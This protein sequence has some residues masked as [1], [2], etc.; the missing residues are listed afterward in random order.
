MKLQL[1]FEDHA[2]EVRYDKASPL[3]QSTKS[4][5]PRVLTRSQEG[6][7][8]GKT[9]LE[10][11]ADLEAKYKIVETFWEMEEDDFVEMLEDAFADTIEEVMT[12]E[13][14]SKKGVSIKETDKIEAKFRQNLANRRYDGVIS[15]VPTTA[16][17]RGVS[18][19]RQHPYAKRAPRPSF[20]DT[21]MYQRSFR[22]W[23]EDIDDDE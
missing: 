22:V 1:G 5:K 20:I 10:V 13:K 16:S 2:Y 3:T 9:T 17:Q 14:V 19:L 11:A 15:G 23:V 4:K 6:Y 12:V 21:G 8:Q 7:G 18:H